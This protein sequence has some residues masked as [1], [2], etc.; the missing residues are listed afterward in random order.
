MMSTKFN[1]KNMTQAFALACV[2]LVGFN[3][4]QGMKKIDFSNEQKKLEE[5]K[6]LEEMKKKSSDLEKEKK[7]DIFDNKLTNVNT[8][9]QLILCNNYTLKGTKDTDDAGI[10]SFVQNY[11]CEQVTDLTL[12]GCTKVTDKG[13]GALVQYCKNLGDIK[14]DFTQVTG[15]TITFEKLKRLELRCCKNVTVKGLATII[16]HCTWLTWFD[17]SGCPITD[18]GLQAIGENLASTYYSRCQPINNLTLTN[19]TQITD[20]GLEGVLKHL[21]SLEGLYLR[22]CVQITNTG[23]KV[24]GENCKCLWYIDL[25]GCPQIAAD[26]LKAIGNCEELCTLYLED[27]PQI[28]DAEIKVMGENFKSKRFSSLSLNNTSVMDEGVKNIKETFKSLSSIFLHDTKVSIEM[29]EKL[30]KLQMFVG[31]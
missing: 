23:A 9:N 14:L 12:V 4:A 13:I 8:N 24:I 16:K 27:C 21:K 5:E 1:V 20:V 15:E 22:G 31:F 2:M 6:L 17:L 7:V 25:S 29:K 30:K 19:C 26:G 28:T 18:M 10:I 3:L 11:N